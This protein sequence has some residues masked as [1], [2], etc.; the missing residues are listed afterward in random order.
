MKSLLAAASMSMLT[1]GCS[2]EPP[3]L[4][5]SDYITGLDKPWDVTWTPDGYMLFTE[6]DTG[7]VWAAVGQSAAPIHTV[8]DLNS[9]GEGGLMGI[10][11]SPN[12]RADRYVFLCY[13]S[14]TPDIRIVR[15]Q[16]NQGLTGCRL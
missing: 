13:T 12:F 11:L 4:N 15:Y 8:S 14:T 6:N 10:A 2:P 7:N 9:S 5:L 16:A 3:A 1:L